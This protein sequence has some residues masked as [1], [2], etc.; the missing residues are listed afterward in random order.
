M[1]DYIKGWDVIFA[2]KESFEKKMRCSIYDVLP[3]IGKT[4]L[5]SPTPWIPLGL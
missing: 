5:L 4:T 3:D 1:E 2:V